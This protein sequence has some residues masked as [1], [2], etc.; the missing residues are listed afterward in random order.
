MASIHAAKMDNSPRL[1]RVAELLADGRWYSTLDIIVGAGVCAVNS[2]V[3]ELRA[4][5][6]PVDCRRVGKDRFEYR[7][8]DVGEA[9]GA[10]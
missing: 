7:R 2:C 5:G 1:Q 3:A 6:I 9:H 10:G 4:N 8:A